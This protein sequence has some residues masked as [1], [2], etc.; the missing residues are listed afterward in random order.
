MNW[1]EASFKE[2]IE[3]QHQFPGPYTFKFIAPQDQ[4]ESLQD[5]VPG[6]KISYRNSSGNKYVSATIQAVMQNSAEVIEV[7]EKAHFIKG[8]VAL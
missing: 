8:I 2:K 5:L 4:K 3:S 6:G 1:D 7:Y